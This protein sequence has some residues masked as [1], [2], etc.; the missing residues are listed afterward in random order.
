LVVPADGGAALA[1][2]GTADLAAG[3]VTLAA[4]RIATVVFLAADIAVAV[5]AG[6]MISIGR[7]Y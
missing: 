7:A 6:K 5:A 2:A 4:A 3:R 1:A